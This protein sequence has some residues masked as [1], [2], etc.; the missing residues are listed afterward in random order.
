MHPAS[1]VRLTFPACSDNYS[2]SWYSSSIRRALGRADDGR[3][4]TGE[5]S[6]KGKTVR[7]VRRTADSRTAKWQER[8][9][10][11]HFLM[12]GRRQ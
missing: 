10:K 8:C 11:R 6:T 3:W 5:L 7:R 12:C 9:K 1:P 2:R 4:G